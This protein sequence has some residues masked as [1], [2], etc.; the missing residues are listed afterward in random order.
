[1]LMRLRALFWV[2]ALI[3]TVSGA[4]LEVRPDEASIRPVETGG[5][6]APKA[7]I[8]EFVRIG[9]EGDY[10]IIVRA[11]ALASVRAQGEAWPELALN[12]D[13]LTWQAKA[14]NSEEWK[15][16][17]FEGFLTAATHTIAVENPGESPGG[18]VLIDALTVQAPEHAPDP[19]KSDVQ[20]WNSDGAAREAAAVALAE[21]TF[22]ELRTAEARVVVRDAKGKAVEGATVWVQQQA[23]A[24]LFGCNICGWEQFP[25][26]GLNE[27][28]KR[29]FA[30]LFNYATVPFY[31]ALYEK[32][33]GKPDYGFT[34]AIAAW[35]SKQGIEMKG[36]TLL[37]ANEAGIPP[38]SRGLPGEQMQHARVADLMGR[39]AGKIRFWEVV[40]E[41]VN[42]PG[43]PVGP[44]QAWAREVDPAARLIVNEYGIFYEGY[45]EFRRF[46]EAAIADGVPFDAVGIQAHA[47]VNMA[48]PLDRVRTILDRYAAL[49]KEIHITEF[50]PSSNGRG[51][52][53]APW[54]DTWTEEQQADYAEKFYK[55]CFAHPAVAAI[56]WWDFSDVGAWVPGGGLLRADCSM[57]P[58]YERLRQLIRKDW[59]TDLESLTDAQGHVPFRGSYGRYHVKARYAGINAECDFVLAKDSEKTVSL[60]LGAAP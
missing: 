5:Q 23:H 6:L 12:L 27:T 2:V 16:Y 31:W 60:Q 44:P 36:H 17:E 54:R 49:G 3:W 32:E 29:R 40:N 4:A 45:P 41:P 1:M 35:C 34:D 15:E 50:T 25:E 48:F 33:Q 8:G 9:S 26:P 37:W 59:W 38:W 10:K 43:V 51:V 28:Y 58:A 20:T 22:R 46:L 52:L 11:R 13:R 21:K 53:G 14:I 42:A 55:V 7:M 19:E 18:A 57:K 39:Y 47:P 30:E 56:S 24:F